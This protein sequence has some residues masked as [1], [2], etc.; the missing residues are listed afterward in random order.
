MSDIPEP[1]SINLANHLTRVVTAHEAVALGI[2]T[3][4]QKETVARDTR[5]REAEAARKL[6]ASTRAL[7]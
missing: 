1:E 2:A 3:H 7:E 4:A 5:R 6:Q